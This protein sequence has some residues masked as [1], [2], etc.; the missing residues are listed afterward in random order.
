M[1]NL[2]RASP[3]DILTAWQNGDITFRRCMR[4]TGINDVLEL[5]AAARSSGVEIQGLG[6]RDYALLDRA[7]RLLGNRMDTV[8]FWRQADAR[9]K[10]TSNPACQVSGSV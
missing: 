6:K 1:E 9:S 7:A 5:Y 8:E 2:W 3:H 4:M 10:V